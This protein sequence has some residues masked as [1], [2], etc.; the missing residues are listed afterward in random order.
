MNSSQF[1]PIAK[2]K[3]LGDITFTH[4]DGPDVRIRTDDNSGDLSLGIDVRIVVSMP[5]LVLKNTLSGSGYALRNNDNRLYF[6]TI[7]LELFEDRF[8][9][10]DDLGEYQ[11]SVL[12]EC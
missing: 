8:G 6:V 3:V 7:G 10:G 1:D 12:I 11:R 4:D 9:R 5:S 2:D